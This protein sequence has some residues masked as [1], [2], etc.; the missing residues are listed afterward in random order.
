MNP[1]EFKG[2]WT[3]LKGQAKERWG[4]LTDDDLRQVDGKKDKL[5]GFLQEKYG[6]TKD[7]AEKA[8]D[9]WTDQ[10]RKIKK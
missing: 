4:K 2:V 5:I 3:Q 8:I 9:E 7:R 10:L 1:D 6:W